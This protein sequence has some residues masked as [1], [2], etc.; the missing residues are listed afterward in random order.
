MK[1]IYRL[2]LSSLFAIIPMSFAQAA[3]LVDF[4]SPFICTRDINAWGKPSH[5]SC[6]DETRY[7]RR[8]GRCLAGDADIVSVEGPI[9]SDVLAAGGET[10][11]FVVSNANSGDYELVLSF[12]QKFLIEE[13]K[14]KGLTYKIDGELVNVPGVEINKRPTILVDSIE[15][16]AAGE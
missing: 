8:I 6:P 9:A 2:V 7:D 13:A 1:H 16:L 14:N 10:T 3:E 12:E 11:G 4:G 5:C 15:V